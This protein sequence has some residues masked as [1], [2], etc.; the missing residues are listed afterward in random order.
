MKVIFTKNLKGQ[1]K[2]G[3]VKEVKDGYGS[4]FLIKNGYAILATPNNLS[5]LQKSLEE[6]ALEEN[7]LIKDKE[8][9]KKKLEKEKIVFFLQTGKNGKL[10]GT[11]TSKQIREKL[12]TLGYKI[13]KK[14]I[15]MDHTLDTLGIHNVD[16]NLHK[17]VKAII[18]VEIK[19]K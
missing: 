8:V 10:F 4:N 14:D 19:S 16:I 12:S 18:K 15:H 2:I 3:D 7:L 6:Q 9:E 13:D 5:K 1:G 11:V 17:K